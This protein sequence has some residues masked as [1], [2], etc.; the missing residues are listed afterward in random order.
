MFIEDFL[1]LYVC[2]EAL[3]EHYNTFVKPSQPIMGAKKQLWTVWEQNEENTVFIES[4]HN[5]KTID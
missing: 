2:G 4:G 1:Y 5:H 3:A